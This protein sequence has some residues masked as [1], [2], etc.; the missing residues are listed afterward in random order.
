MTSPL[1]RLNFAKLHTQTPMRRFLWFVCINLCASGAA[2]QSFELADLQENYKGLIG[3]TIKA[4]LHFRNTSDRPITLVVR[5]IS[6]QIGGTQKNY[7]CLDNSCLDQK[8][9]DHIVKIEPNQTFTMLQVALEGGLASGL[10]SI[11]YVAFNKTNPTELI[12]FELNFLVEEKSPVQNIYSSRFIAL[13]DVYPNPVSEHAFVEYKVLDDHV[14]AKIVIHNILGNVI[15]EY[16]LPP[17]ENKVKIRADALS[18]GIYFYTLYVDN[19][20]VVTRKLIVK[21]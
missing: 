18:A 2:A 20:G 10:S 21:K 12:E 14:K 8:I 1:K 17:L 19:E 6:D 13:H 3:E 11:R 7:F 5:K 9:E 4:P 15:E 16:L